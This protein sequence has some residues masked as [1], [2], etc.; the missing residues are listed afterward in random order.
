M[1]TAHLI[2][3]HN[4]ALVAL[5]V[6]IAMFA[7]YAALDLAG[8]VTAA[9]GWIR[10]VWL[11]GGAGAMG[12]GI[13]S[14][15]YIG[16]L[17]FILPI[18]VAYH[19]PTVLLS[20]FAAI[21]ASVVALGVVSQQKM[22][23]F[24]AFAGSVLMGAGIAG[25]HYIGMAA[26]RLPAICQFKSFLVVLSVV[27]AVLI[28]LAALWITFHFRNAKTGIGWER[29]AGAV[30]MGAAIP[31]MHYTGMA[32]ASFTPSG[33]PLDLSHAVSISILGTG[34]IAAVTFTVLGLALLT[35]WLDRRFA[36][37]TLELQEEKLQRSE[38]YL[39]EAQRLTHTGSWAWR[40]AG[41]DALHLSEE[42]YRIYGFD[43]KEGLSAWEKRLSRIHPEDR[44]KWQEATDR[45]IGEK[46]DYEVQ[47]RI[48]LRD[49]TVKHIHTFGHPVLDASGDLVQFVGA[50]WVI[51]P[52]NKTR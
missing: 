10:A 9:G 30:V 26:M 50:R 20:L 7:S 29:L 19:W 39:A 22:G 15:H 5:S 1:A 49:G 12:T 21:V 45:A 46:S 33:M 35:S 13:W 37:Q 2:C 27:F 3:S 47:F 51:V 32:A 52:N 31:V 8:R 42:W 34:G 36:A 18:P 41:R 4:Y 14:M 17:A 43:P 48:L 6:L 11:L 38:A 16:M 44:A 23:W 40:V 25:M 24:R 28:S